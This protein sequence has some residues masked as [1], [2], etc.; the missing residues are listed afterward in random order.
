MNQEG[1]VVFTGIFENVVRPG[2]I[3]KRKGTDLEKLHSATGDETRGM[4]VSTVERIYGWGEW[5]KG[6]YW[7]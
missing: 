5:G 6:R 2:I 4:R 3:R 1:K 7:E